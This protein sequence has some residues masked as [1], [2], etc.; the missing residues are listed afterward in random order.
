MK[1]LK[2]I[3]VGTG[4]WGVSWIDKLMKHPN[5][6]L[7]ALVDIS[8]DQLDAAVKAYD[9][10]K[11]KC[12]TKL[13]DAL[14][15]VQA[16][17]ALIVVP[18]RQ[19]RETA[20][21]AFAAGLHV[22]M[23]KPLSDT[24]EDAKAIVAAGE[25]AGKKL[26]VSQNYRFKRA[27]QTA[28]DV[29]A[30]GLAGD[31][32]TVYINFMKAPLFDGFRTEMFEPLIQDMSIHHFDQIRGVLGLNPVSIQARSWNTKWS[33]FKGNPCAQVLFE[34]DNGAVV[35]YMGSWVSNGW[36]TSWDGDWHIQGTGGEITW[37]NN[38]VTLLPSNL[39][40]SVFQDGALEKS[41][42]LYFDLLPME[43]EERMATLH[44]FVSSV[45]EGRQPQTSGADNLYSMAMVLGAA[46]STKDGG[47]V[48]IKDIL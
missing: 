17:A 5:S 16:D 30:R 36:N 26:M 10:E 4:G 1:T 24:I 23:E 31:V 42:R 22:L 37:A 14:K 29:I 41:G 13:S 15:T 27:P 25:K 48:Q 46:E 6:E 45:S 2:I 11:G 7:V 47:I 38:R 3:Q 43:Y 12:F 18:P 44:E 34:M 9:F 20:E 40:G 28:R 39:F 19:H 32:C 33:N 21:E 35:T 8:Q